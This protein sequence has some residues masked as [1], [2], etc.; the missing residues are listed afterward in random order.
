VT[1][2]KIDPVRASTVRREKDGNQDLKVAPEQRP[3]L[4]ARECRVRNLTRT[5]K[6]SKMKREVRETPGLNSGLFTFL[7][8]RYCL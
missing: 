5:A 8:T 6:E 4:A 7:E 1:I 2:E 3:N